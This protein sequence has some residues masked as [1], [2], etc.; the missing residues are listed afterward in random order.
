MSGNHVMGATI[1]RGGKK[2]NAAV[3][4]FWY[5]TGRGAKVSGNKQSEKR[6]L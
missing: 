1:F 2:V 5:R 4:Q 6:V 3:V